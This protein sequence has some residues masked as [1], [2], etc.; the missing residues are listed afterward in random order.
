MMTTRILYFGLM[1]LGLVCGGFIAPVGASEPGNTLIVSAEG[2]VDPNADTYQRDK[3][4]MIDDLR[5]DARRQVIEKAVGTL[6]SSSTLVENYALLEDKVFTQSK[7]LI[8]QIIKESDPWLGKDGLMHILLK[9][10]VYLTDV[11]TALQSMSSGERKSLI[12]AK[13]NPTISV[14]VSAR[15]AQRGANNNA[16]RSPIA[17]NILK[18]HFTGFG[19]RVW[20]EDQAQVL[21]L[22]MV[23]SSVLENDTQ[24]TLSVSQSRAADFTVL[25][26]AKFKSISVTLPSSQTTITK[27]ALTSWTVKCVDN[28]TGEEIY[29]NNKI[30]RRKSWADEDQA[31]E[32]IGRLIGE[33]FNKGFFEKQLLKPTTMYQLQAVGL[34]DYDTG[35]LLKKEFIGLRPVI[36]ID[37]K[38][39]DANGL[40]RYEVEFAGERG[41]FL[42]LLNNTIIRPLNKKCQQ[43]EDCFKLLSAHGDMIKISYQA[44]LD[45]KQL[46][47]K[48]E[49]GLPS[50]LVNAT[51]ER[52]KSVIKDKE[53]MKAVAQLNPEAVKQLA[54]KGDPNATG[55]MKEAVRDF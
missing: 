37:F 35:L 26:E 23:E 51:P 13:G 11:Q 36:N 43:A 2:L 31:L 54:D 29:F 47:E 12:K 10:E 22:Q 19:Y 40:S 21:R 42:Q 20:S 4:L 52:L 7:G 28:H 45:G 33:E 1:M 55:A 15:D 48:F 32:D 49:V 14:A 8:K 46:Q 5:Q 53:K 18:E 24:T 39:F 41:N 6:V 38:D 9:A 30:P 44:K 27:Y 17:E 3:G 16:E 25:G 50:S 34:P